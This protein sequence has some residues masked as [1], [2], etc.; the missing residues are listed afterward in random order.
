M[1]ISEDST[2]SIFFTEAEQGHRHVIQ[3]LKG[4]D[5]AVQWKPLSFERAVFQVWDREE[6][7]KIEAAEEIMRYMRSC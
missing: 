2:A 4:Q 6:D 3:N 1:N 5:R 7:A